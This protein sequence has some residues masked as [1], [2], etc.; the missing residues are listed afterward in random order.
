V[1]VVDTSAWIEFFRASGSAVH[2]TLRRLLRERGD[3]AVTEVVVMELLA[4]GRSQSEVDAMRLRLVSFPVLPLGGLAGFESA[5]GLFRSCRAAGETLRGLSDCLV[6][7]PTIAAR[8]TLLHADR[9]FEV[10]ARHTPLQI[11]PLSA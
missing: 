9:D 5:A 3:L 11:E 7:A 1:I 4:G 2:L 10:L 6:A 8:A